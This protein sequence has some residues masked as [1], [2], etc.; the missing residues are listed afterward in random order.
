MPPKKSNSAIGTMDVSSKVQIDAFILQIRN[1]CRG[2]GLQIWNKQ[3]LSDQIYKDILFIYHVPRLQRSGYL[4]LDIKYIGGGK[5][6]EPSFAALKSLNDPALIATAFKRL[7][8][9]LQSSAVKKLFEGREFAMF[10]IQKKDGAKYIALLNEIIEYASKVELAPYDSDSGHTYFNK[11]LNKANAKTFGQFYTPEAVVKSIIK[12]LDLQSSDIVLDPSCGSCSFLQAGCDSLMKKYRITAEVAFQNLFGI[13]VEPNIYVDG[14][15][16]TFTRFGM[17]PNTEQNIREADAFKVLLAEDKLYDKIPANPPFGADAKSFHDIYFDKTVDA[18]AKK[19]SKKVN[20]NLKFQIPFPNT[21]ESAILFFQMIVQKLKQGGK[22][23]VVM[24][25]TI[26]NDGN[27]DMMKW[28]LECCSLEK[29]VINPAGTFKDKGTGIETFSFIFTKG[30][31]TSV[32]S[33]V[34]L[35]EEETILRTL[36]LDSI[37]EAGWKLQLKEEEKKVEYTGQYSLVRLGTVA[38]GDNG[39]GLTMEETKNC[40]GEYPILSGGQNYCGTFGRYNRPEQT[41]SLSKSGS[42]SGYV[43]WNTTKF[44]ASDCFTVKPNDASVLDNRFLYY[45]LALQQE[46]IYKKYQVGGTI[47]HCYWRDLEALEFVLPPLVIQQQIVTN[48]DRIFA[49]SQDMKDF[50][51]FS[52]KAMDLMLKDPN[53]KLLEDVVLGLRLKRLQLATSDATKSQMEI[54]IR[55][56]EYRGYPQVNLGTLVSG[57]AGENVS[58]AEVEANPGP[59]P[60]VSG[61]REP[62]KSYAKYNREANLMTVSKFGSYAGYVRWNSTPFWSLG[63]F[64]LIP[65]SSETCNYRYLYYNLSLQNQKLYDLQRPGPTTNF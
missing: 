57:K 55:S 30:K 56:V 3:S 23:G 9:E 6:E 36:T 65:K 5:I 64:T 40:P 29:V 43:K 53:G 37:R 60:V 19:N 48:L 27:K 28:F 16:N 39:K 52:D 31:P 42:S 17:L 63:S 50:T 62:S 47:P 58:P 11:D 14:L 32:V 34:M 4:N 44:W 38:S 20:P 45:M 2:R 51:V 21:K 26:L 24:S 25:S 18:K 59:Y 33:I 8:E 35:G 41:I 22:G 49:D 7:W 54:L 1:L 10:P 15:M 46:T 12:E 61:G 13:E